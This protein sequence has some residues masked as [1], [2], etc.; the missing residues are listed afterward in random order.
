MIAAPLIM[1]S[2]AIAVVVGLIVMSEGLN[3]N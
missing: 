1:I 2:I 3:D